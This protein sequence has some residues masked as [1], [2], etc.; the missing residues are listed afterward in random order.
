MMVLYTDVCVHTYVR[1]IYKAIIVGLTW[2][3]ARSSDRN[4]CPNL[5]LCTI[6]D[7]LMGTL[8]LITVVVFLVLIT[9]F[10]AHDSGFGINH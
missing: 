8:E 4:M 3:R 2:R 5:S 7:K 9:P 10:I 6:G 1:G